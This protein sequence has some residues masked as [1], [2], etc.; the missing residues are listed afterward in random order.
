MSNSRI[1]ISNPFEINYNPESKELTLISST[2]V[3]GVKTEVRLDGPATRALFD[4]MM[5]ASTHFGAPLGSDAPS[6]TLQ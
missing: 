6:R 5:V 1:T 4:V 2:P 3:S